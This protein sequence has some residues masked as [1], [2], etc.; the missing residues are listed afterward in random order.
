VLPEC[1][2]TPPTRGHF[3]TDTMSPLPDLQRLPPGEKVRAFSVE[4]D[5]LGFD[6]FD[7][8]DQRITSHHYWT[9]DGRLESWSSPSRYVWLSELDLMGRIAGLKLQAR[10][11]DWTRSPLTSDSSSVIS[12]WWKPNSGTVGASG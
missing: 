10:W 5:A 4:A 7:F 12:V 3:V 6:E 2:T 1:S 11:A 9:E 8:V